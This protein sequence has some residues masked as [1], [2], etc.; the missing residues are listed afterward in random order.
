MPMDPN[1]ED[2]LNAFGGVCGEVAR[3]TGI[4]IDEVKLHMSG[5]Y[6]KCCKAFDESRG[7]QFNT[8]LANSVRRR[9]NDLRALVAGFDRHTNPGY[10]VYSMSGS[11][12][13]CP[14]IVQ[15]DSE[16][17]E[18]INMQNATAIVDLEIA[19]QFFI[20]K[21]SDTDEIKSFLSIGAID[22][23]AVEVLIESASLEDRRAAR[24]NLRQ[25]VKF[26]NFW[27]DMTEQALKGED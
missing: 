13:D 18:P 5:T 19:M 11:I 1:N 4:P 2:A 27:A 15:P 9:A 16:Y 10:K 12:D 25:F 7:W 8:Y 24:R 22:G 21:E 6:M 20:E 3:R 26:V 23:R 17:V 14:E